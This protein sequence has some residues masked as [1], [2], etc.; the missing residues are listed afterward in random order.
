MN[1]R[2]P[3]LLNLWP[4]PRDVNVGHANKVAYLSPAF[5][6]HSM[7][8]P[9]EMTELMS[10]AFG[11]FCDVQQKLITP[12]Q[13]PPDSQF[14]DEPVM[15]ID[16]L[17]IEVQTLDLSLIM[18][19]DESYSLDLTGR[20]A[21]LHASSI[22]GALQG[23]QTF[24]Q[25][26]NADGTLLGWPVVINDRPR[27]AYRGFLVDTSRHFLPL[28]ILLQNLDAMAM[29]KLNVLHWH[30]TD[31][32]SFPLISKSFPQLARKGALSPHSIYSRDDLVRVSEYARQR[33]IRIVVEL[34]MPAHT[35]SWALS[36]PAI[37]SKCP[38]VVK[39]SQL[40]N[41]TLEFTYDVIDILLSEIAS[42][43]P[44]SEYIHLGADEGNVACWTE[45]KQ[46]AAYMKDQDLNGQSLY[47]L[48][49]TRVVVM[50]RKH[51]KKVL[52]WQDGFD[53]HGIP[54]TLANDVTLEYWKFWNYSSI[55]SAQ[56]KG[57]HLLVSIHNYLNDNDSNWIHFWR[58]DPTK[59][60]PSASRNQL[61][62]GGEACMWTEQ[63]NT[64]NFM[65]RSWPRAAAVA[66]RL[67][68]VKELLRHEEAQIRLQRLTDRMVALKWHVA[69]MGAGVDH[70]STFTDPYD[71]K[72][73]DI[74]PSFYKSGDVILQPPPPSDPFV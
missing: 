63:V 12:R 20:I 53:D 61:I 69:P 22:W 39:H 15:V 50:A 48:F 14:S 72:P 74:S 23:L 38:G 42:I 27:Y 47:A 44:D 25:L 52:L 35:K 57:F 49:E 73:D 62:D 1:V 16:R 6:F 64:S 17:S 32:Q 24:S 37:F 28:K 2:Q 68:S 45:D 21:T 36:M 55:S 41:P 65:C 54:D 19:T 31:W 40:L 18:E 66:E 3:A 10:A 46:I 58:N 43:F 67:W 13:P 59:W 60:A 33:G 5:T 26:F 11:R 34:D 51:F 4:L 70:C 9:G 8:A 7:V 29:S 56:E 30:L 71:D